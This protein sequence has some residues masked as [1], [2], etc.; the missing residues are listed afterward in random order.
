MNRR[1]RILYCEGN[2]DGTIGGSY[3]SLLYL[4]SGLDRS[5]YEPIV[6]F[7]D[8]NDLLD[9][10]EQVGADVQVFKRPRPVHLAR[11]NKGIP[12]FVVAAAK[13]LQKA[14]NF[15]RFFIIQ[16]LRYAFWLRRH[17]INLVHLNN[18][19]VRNH[20]WM[21]AAL[22]ARVK[23][24]T[25]ERGINDA[26]T[27]MA[28]FFAK[29]LDQVI[30]IS[31][32]VKDNMV[33][34]GLSSSKLAVIYNG[35]DPD[36]V[37]VQRADDEVRADFGIPPG[38]P[39]IGIVGNIKEW[40]G[41]DI[42]IRAMELLR[43]RHPELVCLIVGTTAESDLYFKTRLESLVLELGLESNVIFTGFQKN[44]A[45]FINV[46]DVVVHAS[47]RPEPFGR[48]LIEAMALGKPVIG[49]RAGAVPEILDEPNCGVTF[50][51]GD[52]TELAQAVSSLLG[53]PKRMR[54]L[55]WNGYKRVRSEFDIRQNIENT[56]ELYSNLLSDA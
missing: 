30:C 16:G 14:I 36:I 44:V 23:C 55:G 10:F 8:R 26:F 48:I 1:R 38:V 4:V 28:R 37:L 12:G 41:Q 22:L 46:M 53:E 20:D 39:V 35:I 34:K 25:H 17:R 6:V 51:P 54:A 33:D 18:S 9:D 29:R 32:A 7:Y 49:S 5:L 40:K 3:Y 19:V 27:P 15:N 24:I 47:V 50:T 45:D 31:E 2:T 11:G 21:W 56:E 43:K 13:L 52:F 42:V